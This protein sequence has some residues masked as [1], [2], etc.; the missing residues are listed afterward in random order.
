M[1]TPREILFDRH[2]DAEA[3]LDC[4][5]RD[6]LEN[7]LRK[8]RVRLGESTPQAAPR[9]V[10]RGGDTAPC[11]APVWLSVLWQELVWP[12]RRAWVGLAALWM[13]IAALHSFSDNDRPVFVSE[14]TA[15]PEIMAA[16]HAQRLLRAELLGSI[17]DQA[18]N[19]AA[20]AP[21]P[22]S[23]RPPASSPRFPS[24][25]DLNNRHLHLQPV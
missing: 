9:T 10:R 23:E 1:K 7:E 13:L 25:A 17:P 20:P 11:P 12:C 8:A 2:R 4:L 22:R 6:V 24:S 16:L 3:R 21:A 14:A 19:S 15:R 18:D 5:R